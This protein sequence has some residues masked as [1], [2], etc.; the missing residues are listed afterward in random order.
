MSKHKFLFANATYGKCST[1][2]FFGCKLHVV[3]NTS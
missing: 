2:W 3:M 1:G